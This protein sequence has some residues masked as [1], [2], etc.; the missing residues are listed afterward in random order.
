MKK[1]FIMG[2]A[3]LFIIQGARAQSK[4]TQDQ[5]S[6]LMVR[7]KTYKE[8]LDLA[9]EQAIKVRAIDSA[10]LVGLVALKQSD[11]RRIAKFQQFKQISATRDKQ[12]K[13]VLS[14]DQFKEYAKFKDEMRG[15]LKELRQANNK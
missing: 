3:S 5:K 15:E 6:E 7:F 10:Y 12:M 4:L 13:D 9:D 1:I 2:M 14:K 8:K 11:V